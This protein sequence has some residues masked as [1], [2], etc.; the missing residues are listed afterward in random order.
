MLDVSPTQLTLLFVWFGVFGLLGNLLLARFVERLGINLAVVLTLSLVALSLLMWPLATTLATTAA[1]LVPWGLGCFSCNSA[2]QARLGTTV[3]ALAP[4]LLALNSSAM[5][6]GQAVGA[7][8][9]GW[10]LSH[11][12][13]GPLSWVALVGVLAA[14]G[15]SVWVG[16]Q[17]VVVSA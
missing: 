3:P 10:L 5:Y 6:F 2:Q 13:F 11:G 9:G 7:S 12:G 1:L 15:L 17:R 14:M 8:S 16:R 4:A